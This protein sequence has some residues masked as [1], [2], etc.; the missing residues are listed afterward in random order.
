[1]SQT[2]KEALAL[3]SRCHRENKMHKPT[4]LY[5]E[6]DL[7]SRENYSIV[8]KEFF[9]EIYQA[10]NG[11][12]ALRLYREKQPD[13]L[14][15][16]ISMPLLN[17]LDLVK[18]IRKDDPDIPIIILS[19]HSDREKLL[20]AVTLKLEAYLLKPIDDI[21]LKETMKRIIEQIQ[22]KEV[23]NLRDDLIW[24]KHNATLIYRDEL[25]KIT[26]KERLLLQILTKHI[27]NYVSHDELIIHIWHDDIPDHSHDNKLIQLIYRFNKKLAQQLPMETHLI[28]NSYTLGYR[29]LSS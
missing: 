15:L 26:K 18:T 21:E 11:K 12:E 22:E 16:D 2:N 3:P 20:Q 19:A 28:E 29:I 14:L 7:E 9:R 24:D 10:E 6:D 13:M 5:A 23:L 17:G 25:V 8:L 1:V 4:L 27:D